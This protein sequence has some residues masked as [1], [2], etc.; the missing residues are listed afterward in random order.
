MNFGIVLCMY[1]LSKTTKK[2]CF[3]F[4]LLLSVLLAH[5]AAFALLCFVLFL[6]L[7]CFLLEPA[8]SSE[9][10]LACLL[11]CWRV[12]V[13]NV[14]GWFGLV[15]L[16]WFILFASSHKRCNNDDTRA[17]TVAHTSTEKLTAHTCANTPAHIRR[18]KENVLQCIRYMALG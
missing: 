1:A 16:D 6:F 13:L 18:E 2:N 14:I 11:T 9:E 5:F 7:L 10:R 17:H 4:A 3:S 8:K 12:N 15:W